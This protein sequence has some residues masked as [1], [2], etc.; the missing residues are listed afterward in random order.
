MVFYSFKFVFYQ[1]YTTQGLEI[2]RVTVVN[3]SLQAVFDSFVKPDKDVI[4]YNTRWDGF[5]L[6][7]ESISEERTVMSWCES[8]L[9]NPAQILRHQ[10]G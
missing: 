2:A 9:L 4:D 3:S 6:I 10:R 7:F 1:C 8:Q 5:N